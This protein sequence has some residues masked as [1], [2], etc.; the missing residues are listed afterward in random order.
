VIVKIIDMKAICSCQQRSLNAALQ[1]ELKASKDVNALQVLESKKSFVYLALLQDEIDKLHQ[2]IEAQKIESCR[3]QPLVSIQNTRPIKDDQ[4]SKILA[5]QNLELHE[6]VQLLQAQLFQSNTVVLNQEDELKHIYNTRNERSLDSTQFEMSRRYTKSDIEIDIHEQNI[7]TWKKESLEMKNLMM[8]KEKQFLL[9]EDLLLQQISRL[10]LSEYNSLNKL[11]DLS[12]RFFE[13]K[14][15]IEEKD[16]MI[17]ISNSRNE[18]LNG[19]LSL[20]RE[21]QRS[22]SPIWDV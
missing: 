21:T 17:S 9:R 22:L 19:R 6:T 15:N 8:R 11:N 5:E 18:T 10:K 14:D 12:D 13:V 20:I 4:S 2:V 7:A 1:S 3:N 16:H